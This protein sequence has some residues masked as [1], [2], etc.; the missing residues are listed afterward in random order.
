MVEFCRQHG[1]PHETCG[2]VIV[3][4]EERELPLLENLYRRGREHGLEVGRL[5]AQQV[6]EIEPHVRCLQG[7]RVPSTGIVDY[8]RVC[9]K[10]ADLIAELEGDLRLDAEVLRVHANGSSQVLETTTGEFKTRF[11]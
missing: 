2:K 7:L 9:L 5:A 1:I 6:R 8:K 10:L 3:A 4:T 11:L